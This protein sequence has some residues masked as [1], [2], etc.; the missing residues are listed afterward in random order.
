MDAVT[1]LMLL[2][3]PQHYDTLIR[4]MVVFTSPLMG[5]YIALTRTRVTDI[6]FKVLAVIILAITFYQLWLWNTSSP[7]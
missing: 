3:M 7:S 6:T 2:L 5:H 1:L 4:L